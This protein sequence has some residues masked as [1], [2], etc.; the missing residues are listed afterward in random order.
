[1]RLPVRAVGPLLGLAVCISVTGP[2]RAQ[3]VE[4]RITIRG[5]YYREVSTRVIQP[6]ME[7]T[8]SLPDGFDVGAHMLVDA[9]SSASVAQGAITDEVFKEKRYEGSVSVGWTRSELRVGAFA[10]YSREPDYVSHTGGLSLTRDVWDRTGTI[11]VSVAFT[12]DDVEPRPPLQPRDLDVWF[13][14]VSYAQVLSPTT[15]AQVGYEAYHLNGFA[16]NPY[17]SHPNLGRE[18]LPQKRLRHALAFRIAQYVPS[19]TLGLQLHYRFYFD[20][21]GLFDTGPWGMAAHTVEARLYKDLGRSVE[22]RLSYRFHWQSRAEFWC[23]S[24]ANIGCYGMTPEF[25]SWDVKFGGLTTQLPELK[26]IWHLTLLSRVPGLAWF[27]GGAV[28]LS[29]GYLFQSTPYGTPFN[30]KNAPPLLGDLPWTRK[31]GGAHLLQTGYSL[32]F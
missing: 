20:Q 13:A 18:D 28:E 19:W 12:H 5:A 17:I 8:K 25:H 3:T 24:R 11:G 2:T 1:M 7:V 21:E 6:M 16:G 30:D 15:L 32:P 10:R 27:S 29:Y 31:Y 9:I 4:D 26:V 14:G 23:N 22:T